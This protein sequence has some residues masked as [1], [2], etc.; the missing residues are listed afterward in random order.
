VVLEA[1]AS[2]L[3]VIVSDTG[4]PCENL[5]PGRTGLVTAARDHHQ[6]SAAMRVLSEDN[7]LRRG[8]GLAAREFLEE[9]SFE[10]AC[11][12]AWKMMEGIA[13]EGAGS[14]P[15]TTAA[16]KHASPAGETVAV[17]EGRVPAPAGRE[18]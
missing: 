8:M 10:R 7:T 17:G 11:G 2:G 4:G 1:Q 12:A 13:F 3:P 5:S 14:V 15:R 18:E 9:R 6:L 16:G